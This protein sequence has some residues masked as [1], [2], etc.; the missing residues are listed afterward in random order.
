M[1]TRNQTHQPNP[2]VNRLRRREIL[3][4]RIRALKKL[5]LSKG[6]IRYK[7]LGEYQAEIQAMK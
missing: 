3:S 5:N 4:K 7:R 6:D 2:S 1:Q